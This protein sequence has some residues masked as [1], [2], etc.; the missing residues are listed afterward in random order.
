MPRATRLLVVTVLAAV[1]VPLVPLA[2]FG[3]RLDA[4]VA[5]WLATEP[6]APM[7]AAAEVGVLA[8]DI[9]LPVPSS[10]VATFGGAVLGI[11]LGTLCAWLGLT[12]GSLAGWALG[13]FAGAAAVGGLPADE[14]TA[15]ESWQ[16]RLGPLAVL[17]TRPLP[18]A[19]EAAALLAGATGMGVGSFLAAAATGNLAVALV[20]SVTGA[21]GRQFDGM[22]AAAIWSLL[23][24]T[25]A[26]WW[27][28][29]RRPGT[30]SA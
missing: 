23:A 14:R 5:A 25:A 18:L 11:P 28:L 12:I 13:R 3:M 7:L 15:I 10:L 24:P 2:V 4:W 9:L 19:A 1:A 27:L 29:R 17:L 26:A 6:P 16:A 20:W 30:D 22:A 21:L 8:A